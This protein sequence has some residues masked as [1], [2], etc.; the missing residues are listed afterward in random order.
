MT[1]GLKLC[2]PALYRTDFVTTRKLSDIVMYEQLSGD[3]WRPLSSSTRGAASLRYRNRVSVTVFSSPDDGFRAFEKYNKG[4]RYSVYI[5]SILQRVPLK[6]RFIFRKVNRL[7]KPRKDGYVLL[8]LIK[9]LSLTRE[10]T[11]LLWWAAADWALCSFEAPV[12][13]EYSNE[14]WSSIEM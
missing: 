1:E 7:R 4:I 3:M 8:Q 13:H 2:W 14:Y 9:T 12:C 11:V 10:S 6:K 5:A